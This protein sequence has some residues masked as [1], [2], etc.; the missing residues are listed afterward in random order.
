MKPHFHSRTLFAVAAVLSGVFIP[1]GCGKTSDAPERRVENGVEVVINGDHPYTVNGK[2][3]RL[4]IREEF[5]IDLED[6]KYA[7]MGISDAAKADVDSKGR[8]IL[9]RQYLDDGPL[10]Y[11]FDQQGKFMKSFGRKG[12]GPSEITYPYPIG[13]TEADEIVIRESSSKILYFDE[14]GVLL[15]TDTNLS[16]PIMGRLGILPLA[17]GSYLIQYRTIGS[18]GDTMDLS[19]GVFDSRFRKIK[20]LA[21]IHIPDIEKISNPFVTM[22]IFCCS[23]DEIFIGLTEGEG[24]VSVFD[25]N[26]NLKRTI[27]KRSHPVAIPASFREDLLKRIPEGHPVRKNLMLPSHFPA[28]QSFFADDEDRLYVVSYEKDSASGQNICEIFS[29]DGT[30]I[31]R[32]ALG[33]FDFLKWMFEGQPGEVVIRNGRV[34]CVRDKDSGYREAI[35]SSMTWN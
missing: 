4:E 11:I 35:V 12:Q 28:F 3:A 22:Q 27:R 17:N 2:P 10:V 8:V 29:P 13:V 18:R 23:R 9:F 14:N 16:V 6:P 5:R 15:R 7:E 25:L 19:V 31:H 21:S 30:Y 20:D 24:D 33:Y 34:L 1:A 32:A 26:G